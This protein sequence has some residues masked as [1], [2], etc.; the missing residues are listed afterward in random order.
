MTTN[1]CDPLRW[2]VSVER[3]RYDSP[4]RW[5]WRSFFSRGFILLRIDRCMNVVSCFRRTMFTCDVPIRRALYWSSRFRFERHTPLPRSTMTS[6]QH[7]SHQLSCQRTVQEFP[8]TGLWNRQ[9]YTA[10]FKSSSSNFFSV[11]LPW[12]CTIVTLVTISPLK[13]TRHIPSVTSSWEV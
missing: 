6:E 10:F 3:S 1:M 4:C 12:V 7:I 5:S 9:Q 8:Q 2:R 11:I 13:Y